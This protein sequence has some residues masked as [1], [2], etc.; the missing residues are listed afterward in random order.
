MIKYNR[1]FATIAAVTLPAIASAQTITCPDPAEVFATAGTASL[2]VSVPQLASIVSGAELN[3]RDLSEVANT[4]R[5]DYPEANDPEIA[6]LMIA[7]YC[8]YLRDEA[9]TDQRNEANMEHVRE[10]G[11]QCHL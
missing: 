11:L 6:D 5:T 1:L 3:D 9:Q 10:A 4:L 7:G 2:V 8:T